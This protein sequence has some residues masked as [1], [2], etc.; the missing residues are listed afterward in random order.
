MLV[1]H[2]WKVLAEEELYKHI[3][4]QSEETL[5]FI[6]D[7]FKTD[8]SLGGRTEAL[9]IDLVESASIVL[10]NVNIIIILS[11]CVKVREVWLI[12]FPSNQILELPWSSKSLF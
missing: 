3:V 5:E 12:G 7:K 1:S 6:S 10:E 8:I 2:L 11:A 4:I 9:A